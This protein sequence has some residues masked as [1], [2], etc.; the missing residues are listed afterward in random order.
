MQ[1]KQCKICQIE[2]P[3]ALFSVGR[4]SH[5]TGKK[6][7]RNVCNFCR[8]ELYYGKHK[9][10]AR[11]PQEQTTNSDEKKKIFLAKMRIANKSWRE[12]NKEKWAIL[13]RANRHR[14]RTLGRIN[15]RGWMEKLLKLGNK[16][17]SCGVSGERTQITIDHKNPII[18]GGGNELDNL[19]PLCMACNHTKFTKFIDFELIPV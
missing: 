11:L 3:I 5:T 10:G 14:R 19:Q 16:C 4:T 8:Y 1:G 13:N 15:V 18:K 12:N 2:K 9:R 17:L 7:R 6:F